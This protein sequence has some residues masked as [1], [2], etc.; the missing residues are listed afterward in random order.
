MTVY[1]VIPFLVLLFGCIYNTRLSERSAR[2]L[3]LFLMFS[4]LFFFMAFRHMSV[5]TDNL[6]YTKSYMLRR[7]WPWSEVLT[8]GIRS[9]MPVYYLFCKLI[10]TIFP[11]QQ[12]LSIISAAIIC[13]C[14]AV[15]IE[16][17][18]DNVV[19]SVYCYVMLWFYPTSFNITRQY[20]AMS[21]VLL[22]FC[23]MD[24]G[25]TVKAVVLSLLAIGIH[26]TAVVAL[27]FLFLMKIRITK[28]VLM[29]ILIGGL[30]AI[31]VVRFLFDPLVSLFSRLFPRY[32]MYLG[33]IK[34][35]VWDTGRGDNIF[36]ILYYAI[37]AAAAT[38]ILWINL[39]NS[40]QVP[41]E[42][43]RLYLCICVGVV[44]GLA[45]AG[46]LA[47]T[48][49]REYFLIMMCCF[50]PNTIRYFKKRRFLISMGNCL[51]LW[52]PYY[53]CMS[54]NFSLVVP[55]RFFWQ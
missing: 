5:G 6:A 17:F 26:N 29:T 55:Y 33:G 28:R 3:Y 31:V 18:S 9:S 37:F 46:N 13:G 22:A 24:G 20:T 8:E 11:Y 49:V 39:S 38:I 7:N 32:A 54:R 42:L 34:F 14:V 48:R 50:I 53:I 10:Y 27:P 12:T 16:H 44:F 41:E 23:L 45:M 51:L 2:K 35:T 1:I 19:E 36:L 15:F 40:Q 4:L 52:L 30:S 25:K 47:L 43:E 21:L